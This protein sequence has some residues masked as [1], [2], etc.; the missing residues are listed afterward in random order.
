[1]Y[2]TALKNFDFGSASALSLVLLGIV[3]CIVIV[4]FKQLRRVYE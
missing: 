4:F 1:V 2:R 3:M